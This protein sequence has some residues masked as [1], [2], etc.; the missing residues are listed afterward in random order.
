MGN[1]GSVGATRPPK[2]KVLDLVNL[3]ETTNNY[4]LDPNKNH[5]KIA[6][7]GCCRA[8]ADAKNTCHERGWRYPRMELPLEEREF[9]WVDGYGIGGE[10]AKGKGDGCEMCSGEPGCECPKSGVWGYRPSVRRIEYLANDQDCC[11][12]YREE[13]K[14]YVADGGD[15]KSFRFT[16]RM[17]VV[18]NDTATGTKEGPKDGVTC[19]PDWQP[20]PDQCGTSSAPD[21]APPISTPAPEPPQES[22]GLFSA[23]YIPAL[24][25]GIICC[26]LCVFFFVYITRYLW[27]RKKVTQ[28]PFGFPFRPDKWKTFL[29]AMR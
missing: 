12:K 24:I 7:T 3:I 16:G 25:F 23:S 14:K 21:D 20:E 13:L 29:E 2:W 5:I 19:R 18:G 4:D 15:E 11:N 17:R 26:L 22:T 8:G 6:T 1:C 9:D 10:V 27:L 28:I